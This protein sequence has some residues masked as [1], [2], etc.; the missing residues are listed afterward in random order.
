[1]VD[2]GAERIDRMNKELD[3]FRKENDLNE[4]WKNDLKIFFENCEPNA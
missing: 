3:D 4:H 2:H 1:M